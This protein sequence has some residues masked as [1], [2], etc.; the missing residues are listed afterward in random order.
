MDFI[1]MLIRVSASLGWGNAAVRTCGTSTRRKV[2]K[3]KKKKQGR[4]AST[5]VP[6]PARS[7]QP[8]HR[9]TLST[10]DFNASQGSYAQR[11]IFRVLNLSPHFTHRQPQ[12]FCK[13]A[14]QGGPWSP[15]LGSLDRRS[16]AS[17]EARS[18]SAASSVFSSPPY[19]PLNPGVSSPGGLGARRA[20]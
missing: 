18:K 11:R 20:G 7:D 1:G 12:R 5:F 4:A 13:P 10:P 16:P 19:S 6:S 14:A 2:K 3:K 8:G 17:L 9:K 15:G